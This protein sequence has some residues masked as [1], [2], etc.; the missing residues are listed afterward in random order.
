MTRSYKLIFAL[1]AICALAVAGCGIEDTEVAPD[2]DNSGL[3]GKGGSGSKGSTPSKGGTTKGASK[4]DACYK[5]C[6]GK[7]AGFEVCKKACY[8]DKKKDTGKGKCGYDKGKSSKGAF[9][10]KCYFACVKKGYDSAT[11][12]KT[13]YSAAKKAP[14]KKTD[15][16]ACYL[17][18]VKKGKDA[19]ACKKYCYSSKTKTDPGKDCYD[20]CKKKGYDSATCKKVCYAKK[21]PAKKPS[22][23]KTTKAGCKKYQ[24]KGGKWCYVCW[25]SNGKITK[26]G[27]K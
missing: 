4:Q 8:G 5:A 20:G 26:K 19:A 13:C 3:W 27:C 11:C 22:T 24:D 12:K 7:G 25:D 10:H 6:I 21:T 2:E 15:P 23:K 16:K 9:D 17:G 14:V 18:C 1:L